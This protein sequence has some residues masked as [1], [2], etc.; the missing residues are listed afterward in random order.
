V[1]TDRLLDAAEVAELLH[2]PERWVREHTRGGLIP[3]VRLGR[4]IR[5]RREAID[6][7][8][9]ANEQDGAAWR[10]HQPVRTGGTK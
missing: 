1:V 6:A 10:R 4:Y 3:C 7:W 9:D 5:Y 2:V 8:V